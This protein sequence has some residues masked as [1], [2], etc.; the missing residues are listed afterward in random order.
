MSNVWCG[1]SDLDA[2]FGPLAAVD[3]TDP[4]WYQVGAEKRCN[5]I[6]AVAAIG[7]VISIILP[8]IVQWILIKKIESSGEAVRKYYIVFRIEVCALVGVGRDFC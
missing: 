8:M 6:A 5:I 4:S 2:M 7:I 3:C 1:R